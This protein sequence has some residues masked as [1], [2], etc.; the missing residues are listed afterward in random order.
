MLLSTIY[1]LFPGLSSAVHTA[2]QALLWAVAL[3]WRWRWLWWSVWPL[4]RFCLN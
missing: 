2:L 3:W 1:Y 4:R